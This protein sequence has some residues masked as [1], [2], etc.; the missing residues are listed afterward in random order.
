[1]ADLLAQQKGDGIPTAVDTNVNGSKSYKTFAISGSKYKS[2]AFGYVYDKGKQGGGEYNQRGIAFSSGDVTPLT[3]P[4][5]NETQLV[6][7]AGDAYMGGVDGDIFK[8]TSNFDVYFAQHKLTGRMDFSK[9]PM[10]EKRLTPGYTQ[11]Q[12][13]SM[14]KEI[15]FNATITGNS[16]D[17]S[18]EGKGG[19]V[20]ES[21]KAQGQFYGEGAREL[22]GVFTSQ[23]P[24][25]GWRSGSFGAIKQ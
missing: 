23:D 5:F 10:N 18:G 16:F 4:I 3:D 19:A 12:P 14:P 21:V 25:S 15:T 7:Y 13:T 2:Q 20:P 6:K 17:G 22:G 8:G 11:E 24:W 9:E 1:M